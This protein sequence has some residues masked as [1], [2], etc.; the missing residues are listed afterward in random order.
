MMKI[1]TPECSQLALRHKSSPFSEV[2]VGN[3]EFYPQVALLSVVTTRVQSNLTRGETF[4]S[5][6]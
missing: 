3:D 5:H 1:Y 4:D 2:R 6:D